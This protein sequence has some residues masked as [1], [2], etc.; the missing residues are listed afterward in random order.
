MDAG[1]AIEY[2]RVALRRIALSL[3]AMA[4]FALPANGPQ[5]RADDSAGPRKASREANAAGGDRAMPLRD[6]RHSSGRGTSA[7]AATSRRE[8]P[9]GTPATLP[10]RLHR[11]ILRLLRPA[12]AAARRLVIALARTIVVTLSAPRPHKPRA[13]LRSRPAIL[14]GRTG[15]GIIMPRGM[16]PSAAPL[17]ALPLPLL[18]PPRRPFAIRRACVPPHRAPR[19]SMPGVTVLHRLP[20]PPSSDDML[21][22]RRL[23]LRLA[24]LAS[25]LDDLP[26]HALRFARLRARRVASAARPGSGG[27]AGRCVSLRA[28][29]P[30]ADPTRPCHEVHD[31][32]QHADRLARWALAP[33]DTS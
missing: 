15:T 24:A 4:G 10:R 17:R 19:I 6:S 12:E 31:V 14:R 3:A 29:R 30:P 11:A 23:R 1:P 32:L 18:D 25:A 26:R 16:R 20:P 5:V 9:D 13:R 28:V 33:P 22:A 27:R 2:N 21:D 8:P 7:A